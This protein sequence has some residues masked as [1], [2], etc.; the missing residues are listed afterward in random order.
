[1]KPAFDLIMG[2]QIREPTTEEVRFHVTQIIR[3]IEAMTEGQCDAD[4]LRRIE[5]AQLAF[6]A[7]NRGIIL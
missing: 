1:M 2:P 3:E 7:R 6:E 4:R 5:S